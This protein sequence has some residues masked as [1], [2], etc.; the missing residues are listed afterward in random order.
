MH[1]IQDKT[2][3]SRIIYDCERSVFITDRI[4]KSVWQKFIHTRNSVTRAVQNYSCG[5]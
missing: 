1:S 2:F 4:S 3:Y 5:N